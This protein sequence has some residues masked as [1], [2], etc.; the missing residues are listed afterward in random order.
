MH[1]ITAR[2][3]E[4]IESVLRRFKKFTENEGIQKEYKDRRYFI[5][6]SMKRR[7]KQKESDRKIKSKKFPSKEKDTYSR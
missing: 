6:P 1:D 2:E 5:K 3:G 7:L 4:P